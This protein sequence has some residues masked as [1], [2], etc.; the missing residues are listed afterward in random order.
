MARGTKDHEVETEGLAAGAPVAVSR[1]AIRRQT[2]A[3]Y[4]RAARL[5]DDK[6]ERRALLRL[7]AEL[8]SPGRSE[9]R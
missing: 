1:E 6:A 7:A 5:T 9:R 4:L 3:S 8:L 2:A